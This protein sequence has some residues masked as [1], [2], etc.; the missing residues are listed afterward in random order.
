MTLR[1]LNVGRRTFLAGAALAGTA[2]VPLLAGCGSASN[3]TVATKKA[4]LPTYTALKDGATPDLPGTDVV[5]PMFATAPQK[6]DLFASVKEADLPKLTDPISA[7][8]ISYSPPPP[9]DNTY[10]A[11]ANK[12]MG[13]D[14]SVQIVPAD[15]FTQKLATTVAGNDVPDLVEFLPWNFPPNYPSLLEA[16]FMDIS[17]LVAGDA[18]SAYPNLANIPQLA[19]EAGRINGKIWGVPLHR[20]PFGSVM[21]DRPDLIKQITGEE[22]KPANLAEFEE[23]LKAI[24]SPKDQRYAIAGHT[25]GDTVAWG[26]EFFGPIFDV[27]NEWK[28]DGDKLTH[29]FET[30]GYLEMLD[31]IKGLFAQGF[32]HPDTASLSQSQA[33]AYLGNGTVLMHTDGIASVLDASLPEDVILDAIVPFGKEGGPGGNYQ[34]LSQFSFTAFKKTEEA[35]AKEILKLLNYLAAPFGSEENYFLS[36]G[37]EGVDYTLSPEGLP[38]ATDAGKGQVIP[39]SLNR[40]GQGPQ[41]LTSSVPQTE[42]LTRAHAWQEAAKDMLVKNPVAFLYSPTAVKTTSVANTVLAAGTEFIL[43]R[44][45]IDDVKSAISTWTKNSGDKQRAEFKDQLS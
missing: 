4:E 17:S 21:V 30:D 6:S 8:V 3:E 33:K 10:L 31:Y 26:F 22:P 23:V 5:Q 45:E 19:W 43:G 35:K 42:R 38:V 34:G 32:Y 24:N 41:V 16:Q 1:P 7:F 25:A 13:T 37:V 27:P 36:Y 9:S 2:S 29:K 20:P 39:T 18:I 12:R 15:S 44:K 14:L 11:E 28:L 40:I